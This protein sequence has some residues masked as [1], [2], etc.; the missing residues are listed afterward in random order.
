MGRPVLV[1]LPKCVTSFPL[2]K[3]T[4]IVGNSSYDCKVTKPFV[5]TWLSNEADSSFMSAMLPTLIT[6]LEWILQIIV[7]KN[8]KLFHYLITINMVRVVVWWLSWPYPYWIVWY[9]EYYDLHFLSTKTLL[10]NTRLLVGLLKQLLKTHL[11]IGYN[12]SFIMVK[13]TELGTSDISPTNFVTF[14]TNQLGTLFGKK[15]L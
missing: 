13:S 9:M 4:K 8:W 5:Y 14:S 15:K 3:L 1:W 2:P 7:V 12:F 11:F 6:I 10:L